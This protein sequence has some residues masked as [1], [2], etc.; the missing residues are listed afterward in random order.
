[1]KLNVQPILKNEKKLIKK[2]PKKTPSQP[3]LIF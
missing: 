2:I 3:E 1:M